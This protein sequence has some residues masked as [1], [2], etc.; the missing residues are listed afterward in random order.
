MNSRTELDEVLYQSVVDEEFRALVLA[1][2]SAFGLSDPSFGL[3]IAV[4]PQDRALLDLASGI[5]FT[6]Q[7]GATCSAGPMTILCDGT[8]K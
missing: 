7:C 1:D 3:P 8:T 6:A 2:P 5:Q 4:E